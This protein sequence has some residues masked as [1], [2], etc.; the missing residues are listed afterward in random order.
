MH[1]G[2]KVTVVVPAHNEEET[3]AAV[4]ADYIAAPN[5]DEV[6]VVEN[7][8][9]D[10]TAE[11]AREAGA[12][13]ISESQAGYGHALMAGM[14]AAEGEILVLTEADGSFKASD[15]EKLLVYLDDA[16]L[17]CGTRTTRQMVQQAA[18]MGRLLRLGNITMAKYLE[19][20]WFFPHEPRFTDV[21]CTYRALWRA[22]FDKIDS[23]L[24]CAGP[25]FSPEMMCEVL[26]KKGRCIE[27]PVNYHPRLGG[28]SK[29]SASF[30]KVCKTAW[31]MWKI[32]SRK[33]FFGS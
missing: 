31:G 6:L 30:L 28:E 8:C 19:L 21:G 13:V 3:I 26:M 20:L 12:R 23:S 5:V 24:R 9:K 10:R 32:I 4:V 25:S 11:L 7:N 33:R 29:H 1:K 18:N 22:T 27:I 15:V 14:R 2:V 16:D 17:V